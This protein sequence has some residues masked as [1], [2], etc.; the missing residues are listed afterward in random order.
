MTNMWGKTYR[1]RKYYHT[2]IL[3]IQYI[4]L[5]NKNQDKILLKGSFFGVIGRNS[6]DYGKTDPNMHFC[7][8]LISKNL[9]VFTPPASE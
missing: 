2:A 6:R 7:G 5:R 3:K 4:R 1:K 9:H 8:Q